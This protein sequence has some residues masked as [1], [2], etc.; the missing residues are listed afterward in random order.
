MKRRSLVS[1]AEHM[2]VLLR[3]FGKQKDLIVRDEWESI[4]LYQFLVKNAFSVGFLLRNP[5]VSSGKLEAVG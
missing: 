1:M 3:H 4:F 2:R 5:H